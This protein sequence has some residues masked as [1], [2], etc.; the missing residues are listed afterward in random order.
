M[1]T[2]RSPSIPQITFK[3]TL[4]YRSSDSRPVGLHLVQ[5]S[6]LLNTG[7]L[8]ETSSRP[9]WPTSSSESSSLASKIVNSC[10]QISIQRRRRSAVTSCDIQRKWKFSFQVN[11][12]NGK[13]FL[14]QK[15]SRGQSMSAQNEMALS[16][17][18]KI[19]VSIKRIGGRPDLR[20]SYGSS[21]HCWRPNTRV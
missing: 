21:R 20:S 14:N 17:A 16:N 13:Q 10:Q 18:D 3:L 9:L 15:H 7:A 1:S 5:R 12:A 2:T 11:P 19:L 8:T 6:I 4:S